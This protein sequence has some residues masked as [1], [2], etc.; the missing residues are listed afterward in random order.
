MAAPLAAPLVAAGASLLGGLLGKK[1]TPKRNSRKRNRKDIRMQYRQGHAAQERMEKE[2]F[3]W[4][5]EGAQK[6]GFNPL[7]VLG[8]TGGGQGA[9]PSVTPVLSA[10]PQEGTSTGEVVGNA[11]I[12]GANAYDPIGDETRRLENEIRKQTITSLK[13]QNE[14]FGASVPT[15]R[16]TASPVVEGGPAIGTAKLRPQP[17]PHPAN[18]DRI[19]V[20]ANTGQLVMLLKNIA[21]RERLAPFD[22]VTSGSMAEIAGEGYEIVTAAQYDTV[23]K[24]A[25]DAGIFTSPHDSKTKAEADDYEKRYNRW[26]APGATDDPSG[27]PHY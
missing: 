11:I 20:Y 10:T 16:E 13:G 24:N 12:A 23:F 6:A 17:R 8:A 19:P 15:V 7:T 22:T 3:N 27:Q 18:Q 14:R 26:S 25:F 4:M 5:V 2:R 21:D 9:V 1:K